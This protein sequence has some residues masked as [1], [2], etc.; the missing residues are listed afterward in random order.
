MLSL[1]NVDI[2]DVD[3]ILYLY[4]KDH[5]K[6]FNHYLLKGEFKLV[7]NDNQECKYLITGMIN[8]TTNISWS[9]YLRDAINNLK[10]ER[11]DFNHI[12]EMIIITLA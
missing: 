8:K 4:M 12:V 5:N 6:K 2:K 7:F 3:E 1:K 10:E 11:Y 9:N